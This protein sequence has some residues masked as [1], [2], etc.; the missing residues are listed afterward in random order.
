MAI[1]PIYGNLLADSCG[2]V[3]HFCHILRVVVF[4][5]FV[6]F[7]SL[8]LAFCAVESSPMVMV[9]ANIC[10]IIICLGNVKGVVRI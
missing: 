8:L 1:S 5:L 4:F 2:V 6:L 7:S 10:L 9:N 3:A